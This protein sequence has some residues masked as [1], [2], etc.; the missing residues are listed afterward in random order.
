[1]A[2][3]GFGIR[4]LAL[5]VMYIISNPSLEQLKA[6]K[7][8]KTLSMRKFGQSK[9]IGVPGPQDSHAKLNHQPSGSSAEGNKLQESGY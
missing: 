6:P 4:L 2:A 3:I 9:R 8:A 7:D 5:L 1:M